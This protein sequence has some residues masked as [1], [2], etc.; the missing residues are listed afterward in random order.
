M[1]ALLQA[2]V[3]TDAMSLPHP[4]T[5]VMMPTGQK[6][7]GLHWMTATTQTLAAR[8]ASMTLTTETEVA[9]Q[10]TP[11]I[12]EPLC[13]PL[14]MLGGLCA[15]KPLSIYL[16]VT[17]TT[18]FF[19][20]EGSRSMM[21]D[22][23][24]QVSTGRYLSCGVARADG[25]EGW[26]HLMLPAAH[27]ALA[28]LYHDRGAGHLSPTLHPGGRCLLCPL[29]GVIRPAR[30]SYYV[31]PWGELTWALTSVCTLAFPLHQAFLAQ[32]LD[33]ILF[34]TLCPWFPFTRLPLGLSVAVGHSFLSPLLCIRCHPGVTTFHTDT[35]VI[36]CMHR[37]CSAKEG[38]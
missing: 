7:S 19:R 30:L 15:C 2:L 8:T 28:P 1:Q 23:E 17:K 36:I 32:T 25:R 13:G 18:F 16:A 26:F 5:G 27:T 31:H 11:W 4:L 3:S 20:R 29:R 38:R 21:G 24:G 33:T 10:T 12:G 9:T 6:L 14:A 34:T 22:R 37:C 35:C